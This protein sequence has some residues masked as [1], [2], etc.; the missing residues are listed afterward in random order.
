MEW[1]IEFSRNALKDA[2]KLKAANLDN[3]VKQLIAILKK[4][5]PNLLT[6]NFQAIFKAIIQ[7]A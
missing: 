7:G 2:K 1:K 3:N 5:P 6:K 4:N